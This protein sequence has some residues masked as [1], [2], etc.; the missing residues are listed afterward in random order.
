MDKTE[1]MSM[2]QLLEYFYKAATWDHPDYK[3]ES[4]RRFAEKEKEI[5][6]IREFFVA[7]EFNHVDELMKN[8]PT[9]FK[10]LGEIVAFEIK[11]KNVQV[12]DLTAQVASLK[13]A[14]LTLQNE[15]QKFSEYL[16]LPGDGRLLSVQVIEAFEK[17]TAELEDEKTRAATSEFCCS[18][19][20]ADLDKLKANNLRDAIIGDAEKIRL[21][22]E[23]QREKLKLSYWRDGKEDHEC[24]YEMGNCLICGKD[25]NGCKAEEAQDEL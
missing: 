11:N 19:W 24:E 20:K 3:A 5:A 17:L 6:A 4:L 12:A 25:M 22:A 15:I 21:T 23:L 18:E 8:T 9:Q 13:A 2:E 1:E 10:L 7:A 16:K 14:N